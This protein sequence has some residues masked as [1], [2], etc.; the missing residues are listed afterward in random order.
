MAVIG[1][2]LGIAVGYGVGIPLRS[3]VTS[4]LPPP[5]WPTPFQARTFAQ[6]AVTSVDGDWIRQAVDNLLDNA[7]RFGPTRPGDLTRA[8]AI[9]AAAVAGSKP[10]A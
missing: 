6:A 8:Q 7:L 5:V 1:V 9:T 10:R 3:M 2:L 4:V